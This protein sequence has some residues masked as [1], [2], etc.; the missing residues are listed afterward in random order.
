MPQRVGSCLLL[1]QPTTR[2]HSARRTSTPPHRQFQACHR[3][4][5]RL[6]PRR[7]ACTTR[8]RTEQN[9]F[10]HG[11]RVCTLTPTAARPLSP[12]KLLT[13]DSW[14]RSTTTLLTDAE[15]FVSRAPAHH[16]H[17]EVHR[18]RV[19]FVVGSCVLAGT[20]VVPDPWSE[21]RTGRMDAL[22]W[23]EP[24]RARPNSSPGPRR[25]GSNVPGAEAR[26]H[27][28]ETARSRAG[29]RQSQRTPYA[30]KYLLDKGGS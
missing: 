23:V 24:T 20:F 28:R 15:R 10:V 27:S 16:G 11:A 21:A 7:A 26:G 5:R 12:Q 30:N 3:L 6:R 8:S 22:G 19:Y 13:E 4:Y 17:C 18:G 1:R 14:L 2:A 25:V 9:L 29:T